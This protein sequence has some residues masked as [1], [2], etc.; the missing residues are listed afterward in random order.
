MNSILSG[1]IGLLVWFAVLTWAFFSYPS[2]DNLVVAWPVFVLQ[3]VDAVG[4]LRHRPI[5]FALLLLG[6]TVAVFL[7]FFAI[8]AAAERRS[9]R[10]ADP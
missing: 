2:L 7:V 9:H 8:G 10:K 4:Q 1:T 6:E 5:K 3:G